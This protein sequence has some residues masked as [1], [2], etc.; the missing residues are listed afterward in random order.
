M[1]N[2][3]FFYEKPSFSHQNV[4]R[5]MDVLASNYDNYLKHLYEQSEN[6]VKREDLFIITKLSL[7]SPKWR[8]LIFFL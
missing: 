6:I 1:N 4:L 8:L 5:G 2:L 7:P 3:D